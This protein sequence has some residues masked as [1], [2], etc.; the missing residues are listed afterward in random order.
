MGGQWAALIAQTTATKDMKSASEPS[1]REC[2]ACR[3]REKRTFLKTSD[4][5]GYVSTR[6]H[7]FLCFGYAPVVIFSVLTSRVFFEICEIMRTNPGEE[8]SALADAKTDSPNRLQQQ[9]RPD[10]PTDR[11]TEIPNSLSSLVIPSSLHP[12][13][14]THVASGRFFTTLGGHL[15]LSLSLSSLFVSAD[16]LL[17]WR[18]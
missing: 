2:R 1:T 6:G 13:Y 18:C 12:S 17:C 16:W 3:M 8:A 4:A 14:P 7:P 5:H 15:C 11:P 10:R 9:F